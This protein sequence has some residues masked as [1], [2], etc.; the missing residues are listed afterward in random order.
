[1][2]SRRN[3]ILAAALASLP[4]VASPASAFEL[5]PYDEAAVKKA[6]ASGRPV[7]LHVYAPWC[8]QCRM[9]DSILSDLS[10]RSKDYEGISFFRVSYGDQADVVKALDVPRSTFIAYRRGKETGRM[11]WG[12]TEQ[13]VVDVLKS[14]L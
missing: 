9:Q 6:I 14:A 4:F 5:K 7:V 3:L 10:S 2:I 11:S 1:M 12:M 8:L 13:S